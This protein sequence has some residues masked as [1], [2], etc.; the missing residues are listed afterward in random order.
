MPIAVRRLDRNAVARGQHRLQSRRVTTPQDRHQRRC[1][2]RQGANRAFR[3]RFPALAPVRRRV[4]GSHRQHPVQQQHTALRPGRQIAVR[5]QRIAQ[6]RGVLVEDVGQTARP[7]TYIRGHR[8]AKTHSMSWSR[9]RVLAN[10]KDTDVV[11][12]ESEGAQHIRSG[13]Q[14]SAPGRD[15]GPQE[16]PHVGHL[17]GHRL[18]RGGPP[19]LDELTQRPCGHCIPFAYRRSPRHPSEP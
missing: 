6:I 18:E 7:R 15:L 14:V 2:R 9:I 19:P 3:D 16:L 13:G 8:E 4:A 5:G 12:R 17:V 1:A 11:E 10:D